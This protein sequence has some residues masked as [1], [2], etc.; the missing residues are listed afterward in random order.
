MPVV[1]VR[2]VIVAEGDGYVDLLFTLDEAAAATTSFSWNT[3]NGTATAGSDFSTGSG[4]VSFAAGETQKTVRILLTDDA[5]AEGFESFLVTLGGANGLTLFQNQFLVTLADNEAVAATPGL[6]VRGG[7]FDE[8]A[9]TVSFTVVLNAASTQTVTVDWATVDGSAAA[10]SDYE[11]ATGT[12]VFAPGETVK[13]VAVVLNDDALAEAVERF[14]LELS[15]PVNATLVDAVAHAVIGANDAPVAATPRITVTGAVAGESDGWVEIVLTL[16]APSASV[17]SVT[18]T[19]NAGNGTATAADF[20]P[21]TTIV[22]FAPGETTRTL[23]LQIT[24]D[25][26]AEPVE[27]VAVQLS[28]LVNAASAQ[29]RALVAIVDDD[30]AGGTAPGLSVRDVAVDEAAGTATFTVLLGGAAGQAATG[31]VTVD[32]ATE[33]GSASGDDFVAATGTLSF[34][35]GETVKTFTVD[36]NNDALAEGIEQ[37]ALLLSNASG[38]ELHDARGTATIGASDGVAVATPRIQ[39]DSVV[40]GEGDGWVDV[41]VRLDA[42]GSANV[43]VNV[44]TT[45]ATAT[46]GAAADYLLVSTAVTFAP[47]ETVKTVRIALMDDALA[48]GSES[49]NVVLS[50][51]VGGTVVGNG[52]VTIVD[53]DTV[54]ATPTLAVRDVFVDEAEGVAR[55][56]VTLGGQASATPVRLAYATA[57]GSATAGDDYLAQSGTL[58]FAPGETVRTIEVALRDDGDAEGLESFGLVFSGVEG[59]TLADTRAD[60]FIAASDAAPVA[61]PRLSVHDA[62]VGEG[63]AWVDLL[64]T[65]DAPGTAPVTVTYN[66]FGNSAAP[67][68]GGDFTASSGKLVFAP[69]E[70]A[71]TVRVALTDDTVAENVESFRFSLSL[72]SNATIA[73]AEAR[74]VVVD[75][76]T[77]ATTPGLFVR[78]AVVDERDGTVSFTVLLGGAAGQASAG[79][80]S[81]AYAT[82]GGTATAGSDYV[83]TSGVLQFAPG[84]VVKT[85]TVALVDDAL[86]EAAEW[87]GLTLSDP[88]G[89]VLMQP[90]G[91]AVIGASDAATAATPRLSVADAVVGESDGWVDLVVSLSAPSAS[92][93]SVSFTT[94]NGSAGFFNTAGTDDFTGTSGTISFA[95][96][97]TTQVVRVQIADQLAVEALEHFTFTLSAPVNATLAKGDALVHI[98]DDDTVA[99]APTIVVRDVV[100]DEKDGT[101]TFVVL[102]GGTAGVAADGPVTVDFAT[103]AGSA[104]A[105]TDFS[106][107]SGTLT[108]APG[109]TVKTVKIDLADDFA[110][111]GLERFFLDLSSASGATLVD[112]RAEATIGRSDGTPLATPVLRIADA[113]VGEH[114][115]WVDLVVTLSAPST[116]AVTVQFA[117]Q[118]ATAGSS[119]PADYAFDQGPLVFA[120]GETTKTVRIALN[121]DL[122]DEGLESFTVVLSGATGATIGDSRALVSL[123][124]DERVADAPAL[125]VRDVVVDESAGTATFTVLLGGPQGGPSAAPVTVDFATFGGTAAIGEDFRPASGTLAFAPGETVKTV[126]VELIDDALA[127]GGEQFHL[128]LSNASGAT[129]A[130][131]RGDATIGGNDGAAVTTPTLTVLTAAA[132][133]DAGW[134]DVTLRLSAPATGTVVANY[135]TNLDTATYVGAADYLV[136]TGSIS[137]TPGETTR[138][139]RVQLTDDAV[140]ESTE[141]FLFAITSASGATFSTTPT[142]V[143]I[144]DDDAPD[145]PPPAL[146]VRDAVVDEKAGTA[147]FTVTLGRDG[148]AQSAQ[149]V[150]VQWSTLPGVL[151]GSA[152]AGTDYTGGQGEL[153][154][155]PGQ[156]MQTIAIAIADDALAEF[157]ERFGLRLSNAVGATI[158]DANAVAVIGANDSAA[159]AS[160]GISI[161]DAT[162]VEGEGWV[163]LVVCLSAPSAGTVQVGWATSGSG[164]FG[165]AGGTLVFGAGETLKTVRVNLVVDDSPE[166]DE[167][168]TVMLA[169]AVGGT[170]VKPVATVTQLDDDGGVPVLRYGLA[171]DVYA[172]DSAGDRIVEAADGG[173]DLVVSAAASFALPDHVENLQ[174]VG[175]AVTGI[176]NGLANELLGN[177]GGDSLVGGAGNDS[178]DGGAGLDTL[179]GGTGDDVYTVDT[180]GEVLVEALDAGLDVVFA[181]A[182]TTLAANVE[183][184]LLQGSLAIDG[185]G[186]SGA[187]HLLGNS[188]ANRLQGAAGNDTLDGLAG[189]DT[190]E[191]GLGDDVYWVR[192]AGTVLSESG[193]G[194][195]DTVQSGLAW[196][197]GSG[198]EHLVLL[199]TG[200]IGGTGN[201][202]SNRIAGNTGSNRIDGGAGNDTLAGGTGGETDTLIGGTG[203]D[204][205]VIDSRLDVVTELAAGGTDTIT[206][207]DLYQPV[208]DLVVRLPDAVEHL[209]LTGLQNLRGVGNELAN[210]ITGNNSNNNL[211]GYGGNDTLEGLAGTDVLYGGTGDDLYLVGSLNTTAS[212]SSGGGIDTVQT[213]F[214]FTLGSGLDHLV[215]GGSGAPNGV[216]N[217]LA[218]RITGNA[219]ANTLRGL[220]GNDTLD[221]GAGSDV[222][223]GGLGDD[224]YVVDRATDTVTELASAGSDTVQ[225]SVTLTLASNVENLLLTGS[226]AI[227]GTG[228]GLANRLTGNAGAN[229][230]N[231]SL[232][233][234]TMAGGGG[235]DAY[236]VDNAGDV[237]QEAAGGGTDRVTSSVSFTLA[238][239]VDNLTLTGSAVSGVGNTSNNVIVGNAAA[240]QLVGGAGSDTLTGGAGA[241]GYTL[242]SLVGT[243]TITDYVVAD[244]TLR[245]SQAGIRIG[246]GD[247]LVENA[248]VRLARGGFSTAAELVLFTPNIVGAIT[249]TTAASVIG[250]AT[251][252]YGSG[253]ARLFVVDNG[254]QTGVFRFVSSGSDAT[255]SAGELTMLALLNGTATTALADYVFV[256]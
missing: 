199:G 165:P 74:V 61:A 73:R 207:A 93:V 255:V 203:N 65:L 118:P 177:A 98:V 70:T 240:N 125:S 115:G 254:S 17:V 68:V 53:D 60:A 226:N 124:D 82:G 52:F 101:A 128:E 21:R 92:A 78:D 110:A 15:A 107:A 129:I 90:T 153:V 138:T 218:N 168:F 152:I 36:L 37:F 192:A 24:D 30:G 135:S 134:V 131:A 227:N 83:G 250:A 56:V 29:S 163:E 167:S 26:S 211:Y 180:A 10:G 64:V 233:A 8:S 49:F 193:G 96:G 164:D 14:G 166:S 187:N 229:T 251:S 181:S 63:D 11:G 154:F 147:V 6:S 159:I 213:I 5:L 170:L 87:F 97:E 148:T 242:S 117:T 126:T 231:G 244:D 228:N 47:G 25:T 247:T 103:T 210:R 75:N 109:E 12:L 201:T 189:V 2:E 139:V 205:F 106:A 62:V 105:G 145:T 216:G 102:L 43:T 179:V 44:T 119:S 84:E 34:A 48:E 197:L 246:D 196:T 85:V 71:Q 38:A 243:D 35:P 40:A 100:V 219:N 176:G 55:F 222:L 67:G 132:S 57:D 1:S 224:T 248:Q 232:G 88:S 137:F 146:Y 141:Q 230:L 114:D 253:A 237:V 149:P 33:A 111:E 162:A 234:D 245:I 236:T 80:V 191:G 66:T 241:D 200:A 89:A 206:T 123:V 28:N 217:T 239:N 144:F 155:A 186:N 140:I 72:P 156:S 252:A 169:D 79:P 202:A 195:I 50:G 7:S 77:L 220:E 42:P 161:E 214:S 183:N 13:T 39:L 175:A 95:P 113:I 158:A 58:V 99:D 112:T 120:P 130:D 212:E 127:E 160:P 51:A 94:A 104:T 136:R 86:A 31:T 238:A 190:L 16:D 256:A 223:E 173:E 133:E 185:T 143:T 9:G 198:F 23:Q 215:L 249:A 108:F 157:D 209:L 20:Q 221:G 174:L 225:S 91:R 3:S 142:P 171:D 45:N 208:G 22:N 204:L 172:V 150:T 178:V 18:V 59:A 54:V 184:L 116:S 235:H 188:G 4:T 81:V 46:S 121:D 194:G 122:L 69:G 41:V 32:V 19:A 27:F 182:T 76:D 151:A